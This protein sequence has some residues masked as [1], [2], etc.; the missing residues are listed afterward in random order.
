M[1]APLTPSEQFT[2]DLCTK[3]FLSLWCFNNPL[4]KKD[5]ELCDVLVVCE[6]DVVV[7]SIKEIEL[8][9]PDDEINHQRW[10]RKA[11][12]ASLKQLYGAAKWLSSASNVIYADGKQGIPLPPADSRRIHLVAVAFGSGGQCFTSSGDFGKG[13]VHVFTEQS[14]TDVLTELDTITDFVGYLSA[15]ESFLTKCGSIVCNG[16]ESDLLGF[17]INCGRTFPEDADFLILEPGIWEGVQSKPE[18]LAR[19]FEDSESYKWDQLIEELGGADGHDHSEFGLD[20]TEREFVVRGMAREDRF[21]RRL[22]SNGLV[23]FLLASKTGKTRSRI[24]QS[25]SGYLYVFA[26]FAKDEQRE[27]RMHEL[28]ARCMIARTKV[29]DAFDAVI[30]VGFNEFNPTSRSATDVIYLEVNTSNQDWLQEAQRLEQE[31]GFFK[32][33]ALQRIPADEFP[34]QE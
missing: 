6:P 22:L 11:V 34:K 33:C 29:E 12:D 16:G 8:G 19:K 23:D 9:N 27:Y 28:Y 31:Y 17:Y 2:H 21:C 25:P 3:S 20:L 7:F 1:S 26:Y 32:G 24:V 13:H 4:G 15:K 14:L 30:G 5:K 18:F 10:Q